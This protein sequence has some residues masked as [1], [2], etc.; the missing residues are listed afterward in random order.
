[1]CVASSLIP[2]ASSVNSAHINAPCFLFYSL[3]NLWIIKALIDFF[4][5]NKE[6]F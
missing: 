3:L 4:S 5:Y 6:K 2:L 1:M